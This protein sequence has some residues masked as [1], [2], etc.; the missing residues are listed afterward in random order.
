MDHSPPSPRIELAIEGMSCAACAAR[1]EKQLNKTPGVRDARVNFAT[2]RASL[3]ATPQITLQTLA[4]VVAKAGFTATPIAQ[5][6][7]ARHGREAFELAAAF[8]LALPLWA[9]MVWP[10]PA[11][12]ALALASL[13]QIWLAARFYRGAYAALRAGGA[14]MDVLIAL[15][16][17]AAYGLSLHDF[18]TTGPLYFDSAVSII[19]FIRLGKF[20][21]T[22]IKR[23]TASALTSLKSLA[24][25][26]A[27]LPGGADIAA[28]ALCPG[29]TIEIRP[30]ER[31]PADGVITQGRA[32]IDESLLTGE[33]RP[34]AKS[35]GDPL[36]TGALNLDGLLQL[37][38]TAPPGEH[39]I[40]HLARLV[41]D[42]QAAKPPF[43]RLADRLA[44]WFVPSVL[45]LSGLTFAGWWLHG[46]TPAHALIVAVSVLVIA[47]PC[48]LGL[49]TPAAILA[50]TLAAAKR[51]I[52]LREPAA[53]ERAAKIDTMVLD[54]TG[55]LTSG[56]LTL[57]TTECFG[58][59][60]PEALTLAAA[61]AA[62]NPPPL[63]RALARPDMP[64]PPDFTLIPGQ[65]V[66]ATIGGVPYLLGSARLIPHAPARPGATYLARE[67]GPVLAAFTFTDTLRPHVPATL[68]RLK[69]MGITPLILTGDT[70]S[71]TR[72]L[73][74]DAA[75]IASASP[76]QKLAAIRALQAQGHAV[77]MLGD[78]INDLAALA[79]ADLSLSLATATDAAQ[80]S[81]ALLLLRPDP[82]LA[83]E[84]LS[85]ARAAWRV[86]WQ[87]L[88]WALIY[89]IIALPAA[90][91]GLLSPGLAAAA[92]AASSLSV[93]G[94]ALRL[95]H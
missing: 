68:A 95:R 46:A 77:A 19:A 81:A 14:D 38:V 29:Q 93:L 34:L 62:A 76:E 48:A 54:K 73:G 45:L 11:W 56:A 63:G 66:R 91:L 17:S 80:D 15:G 49:A 25:A 35:P 64:A 89:N 6:A 44:A 33:S 70:E 87:G 47:C 5:P 67:N 86:L 51:G 57:A 13:A 40:D 79:G 32:L 74:L 88:A 69:T 90:A 22:R 28:A 50:A 39:F 27:H 53:L 43:Q 59:P 12:V 78:G 31:I 58:I 60:E 75:I 84:A 4:E 52:V 10:L 85:L 16:T 7:P 94:N 42:A 61:L 26:I 24:P 36:L 37:R 72:A 23:Q 8:A 71:A 92:M 1:L 82:A 21:E 3:T 55:T 20:L 83:A 41:A 9:G 65:G 2:E 18:L 30:A